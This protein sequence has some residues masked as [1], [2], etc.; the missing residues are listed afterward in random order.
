MP[1]GQS[2]A[3]PLP[4]SI[5]AEICTGSQRFVLRL[6][7]SS[8]YVQITR[9][10]EFVNSMNDERMQHR[11]YKEN[12]QQIESSTTTK[13]NSERKKGLIL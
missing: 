6:E 10:S 8:K 9:V 5:Y 2:S 3:S 13:L 12:I 1:E 11:I 4:C 7:I